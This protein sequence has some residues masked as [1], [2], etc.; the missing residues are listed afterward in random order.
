MVGPMMT[1]RVEKVWNFVVEFKTRHGVAPSYR[2]IGEAC[3]INSTSLVSFYLSQL[4]RAGRIKRLA[5]V[6]R[7]ILIVENGGE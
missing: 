6:S 2:E 4:E 3:Q 1:D 5:G 7:G